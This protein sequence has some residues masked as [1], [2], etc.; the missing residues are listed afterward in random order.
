VK[1]LLDTVVARINAARLQRHPGQ[2]S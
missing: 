2:L 1:E